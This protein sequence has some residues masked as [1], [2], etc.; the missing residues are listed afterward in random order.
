MVIL[1]FLFLFQFNIANPTTGCQKKLEIDDDQ[2]LYVSLRPKFCIFGKFLYFLG[3]LFGWWESE[4]KYMILTCWM[5]KQ[6]WD[7]FFFAFYLWY[8]GKFQNNL[9]V[10][11]LMLWLV[12]TVLSLFDLESI[13]S[14]LMLCCFDCKN[15]L[16]IIFND[17]AEHFSTRGSHKK[18]VVMLLGR[19]VLH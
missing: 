18:L 7:N 13:S 16:M 3:V 17:A 1:L 15:F 4:R 11:S 10:C 14:S 2:K 12:F 19:Y 6:F 8:N 9:R 5:L